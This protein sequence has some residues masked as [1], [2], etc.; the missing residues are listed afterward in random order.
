MRTLTRIKRLS[1]GIG[2]V[3]ALTVGAIV[4]AVADNVTG[5]ASVTGGT[6]SMSAT[7]APA[8]SATLNGTDQTPTDPFNIDVNDATGS[9]SGWNL[10]IT[11]T[12][13]S[14][15]GTTPKTLSTS[16]SS[17]SAVSTVCDAGT[18]TAPTSNITLPVTVPAGATAPAAVK[19]YNAT[20]N[21]GM[22]DFTVTP[23]FKVSI[24]ANTYAGSYS[25]TVTLSVAS[26]P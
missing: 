13:F 5:T 3:T 1:I 25:S 10:Q 12:T 7:D 23:T 11:S 22:G 6:L 20:A 4:P 21:T 2:I 14:T 19:F 9:G 24:P 16:A 8:V 15:G 18:C 26:G 17:I